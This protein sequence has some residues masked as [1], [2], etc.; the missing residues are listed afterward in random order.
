MRDLERL[1][2]FL[3][4]LLI[5][6]GI[7]TSLLAV[8]LLGQGWGAVLLNLGT[9]LLGAVATYFVFELTIERREKRETEKK[10]AEARKARLVAEMGSAVNDVAVAAV[11]EL[12]REGWLTDG[13][14]K[15]VGIAGANL[16][17][18]S[19]GSADL[20]SAILLGA[21]LRGAFLT[22]AN[23]RG[24]ILLAANLEGVSLVMADLVG[25]DLQGVNLESANLE[26]AAVSAEQLTQAQSLAGA[27]LPDGTK[28]SEDNWEAEFEE[29]RRK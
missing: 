8:L 3:L 19:L 2:W 27:T 14:L 23:L 16:Q 20:E 10:A 22:L 4:G 9:E 1:R 25:A 24:A 11:E 17:A 29:W 12:R 26:G 5:V 21:N 18:S 15:E 7:G 28:L 13:T 6:S